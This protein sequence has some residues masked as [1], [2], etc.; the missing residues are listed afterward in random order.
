MILFS[1][2]PAGCMTYFFGSDV[3]EMEK[4]SPSVEDNFS[5][6][7]A[8]EFLLHTFN[9]LRLLSSRPERNRKRRFK[10]GGEKVRKSRGKYF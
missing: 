6:V 9:N 1:G 7:K 8:T 5:L 4:E 3:L 2:F 10:K